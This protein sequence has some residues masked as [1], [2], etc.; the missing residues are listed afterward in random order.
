MRWPA[1]SHTENQHALL[2]FLFLRFLDSSR[3][4]R[5]LLRL[6]V[7]LVATNGTTS[8]STQH[9]VPASDVTSNAAYCRAFQTA[10]GFCSLR[11]DGNATHQSDGDKGSFHGFFQELFNKLRIAIQPCELSQTTSNCHVSWCPASCSWLQR[12]PPH[13]NNNILA[14][15]I[16][17]VYHTHS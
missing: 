11:K 13:L 6:F 14:R 16:I 2:D 10:F 4:N 12:I 9:A 3:L 15:M 5:F 17:N 1:A 8:C 7:S